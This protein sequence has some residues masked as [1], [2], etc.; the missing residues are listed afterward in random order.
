MGRQTDSVAE[1][2][3]EVTDAGEARALSEGTEVP[4]ARALSEGTGATEARALSEGTDA[5]GAPSQPA[6]EDAPE[7]EPQFDAKSFYKNVFRIALPIAIQSLVTSLVD[8]SDTLML[9]A[10]SQ[11][12]LSAISLATQVHFV[13]NMLFISINVVISSM[14]AQYW[15]KGDHVT[16][17]KVLAFSLKISLGAAFIFFAAA[18]FAP[19]LLM[20]AFTSDET[21]IELGIQYLRIVSFSYLF[22]GISHPF[23]C[24]M[25]NS[26]RV[27]KSSVFSMT[28]VVLNLVLNA[29]LIY[30]L[31][32][33][34][35]MEIRGAALA[36]LISHGTCALLCAI[37]SI[38]AK[39]G[40]FRFR[41]FF[42]F[43]LRFRSKDTA[44]A[45][46]D[47]LLQ[48]LHPEHDK[49]QRHQT[50]RCAYRAEFSFSFFSVVQRVLL[51]AL[52]LSP[53]IQAKSA[54]R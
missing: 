11:D 33:F 23:L 52:I 4:E 30:G 26:G 7:P 29:L 37:E 46:I 41:Y 18:F 20:L 3:I 19:R 44:E 45:E 50:D 31:L 14:A 35:K 49:S 22:L 15:G 1:P 13:L 27:T 21:L 16:V 53:A 25:K 38:H 24:I 47:Q 9:A 34:P 32:G 42:R 5:S 17:E 12:A 10:L 40:K 2:I 54:M 8:A 39:K 51:D 43:L 28:S 48:T 6:A 36:T